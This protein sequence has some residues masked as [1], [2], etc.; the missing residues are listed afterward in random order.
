MALSPWMPERPPEYKISLS[1]SI[2]APP[3]KVYVED[4]TIEGASGL[5]Q[6]I[7]RVVQLADSEETR[8]SI[9]RSECSAGATSRSS[10]GPH[11]DW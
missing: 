10:R 7:W 2:S 1:L 5:E 9:P 6:S 3:V 4:L 11:V 8:D